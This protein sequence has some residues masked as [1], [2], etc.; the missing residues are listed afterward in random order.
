MDVMKDVL[1]KLW[2]SRMNKQK[3]DKLV[4]GFKLYNEVMQEIWKFLTILLFGV[5]IGYLLQR[6]GPENNNRLVFTL[7]I[8][9]ALGL[10]SF[11]IG[12]L[13]V[14]KKEEKRRLEKNNQENE[15]TEL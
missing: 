1:I 4:H 3:K 14:I 6:N 11:F 8:A 9:L 15:K 2:K 13:K 5:L 7:I 12:L 10:V